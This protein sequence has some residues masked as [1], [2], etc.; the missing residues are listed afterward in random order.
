MLPKDDVNILFL[1]DEGLGPCM[2]TDQSGFI[3]MLLY[4]INEAILIPAVIDKSTHRPIASMWLYL[5]KKH[6]DKIG[7]AS[8]FSEVNHKFDADEYA[9]IRK[10]ILNELSY[11]IYQY[12][13]D[14][15]QING[16]FINRI[17]RVWNNWNRHWNNHPHA[18]RVF[19]KDILCGSF[20][21]QLITVAGTAVTT[22]S[23][24]YNL[25]SLNR[26]SFHQFDADIL[27]V[28]RNKDSQVVISIN[29][30]INKEVCEL[31]EAKTTIPFSPDKIAQQLISKNFYIL[32]Y[33]FE[34]PFENQ[35][36]LN[37]IIAKCQEINSISSLKR[38]NFISSSQPSNQKSSSL[39]IAPNENPIALSIVIS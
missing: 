31:T 6:D 22:T 28:E 12:L 30:L 19:F 39:S 29:D 11:F 10:I 18:A 27:N 38:G 26:N 24:I 34:K 4:R 3:Q 2:A 15:P 14:N 8:D 17:T 20:L 32:E 21:S 7:L 16:F 1:G 33:F 13:L 35:K 5:G 37:L 25:E 23:E 9:D 36:L